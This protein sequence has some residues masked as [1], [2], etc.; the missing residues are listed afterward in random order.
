MIA[1]SVSLAGVA[2]LL[3]AAPVLAADA[4]TPP[5]ASKPPFQLFLESPTRENFIKAQGQVTSARDYEPYSQDLDEVQ[6]LLENKKFAEA[7]A[8]LKAGQGNLLLSPRAHQYA[9]MAAE[10]LGDPEKAKQEKDV[11]EKCLK[12]L[13]STGD[14]SA[15]R[16]IVVT[17]ISDEYDVARHL[18]ERVVGQGLR[19][20]DGKACNVLQL[21]GGTE[22][23]FDTTVPFGKLSAKLSKP[24]GKRPAVKEPAGSK[25]ATK[26]SPVRPKE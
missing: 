13:L 14:G 9:A 1:R 24:R 23:W 4:E 22:M 15:E 10:K 26:P 3:T 18:G 6:D 8:R 11:A 20:K 19:S 7:Q 12:G 2:F 16:P 17:R 5:P 25:P 21:R